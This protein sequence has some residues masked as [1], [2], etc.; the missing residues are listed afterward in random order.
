MLRALVLPAV[1]GLVM[2]IK[3]VQRRRDEARQVN[4]INIEAKTVRKLA[5]PFR[6]G[7]GSDDHEHRSHGR[8][9]EV[10]RQRMATQPFEDAERRQLR[11]RHRFQRNMECLLQSA[12]A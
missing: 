8:G 2:A 11:M 6:E 9:P 12:M 7:T 3:L 10:L 4:S 1:H 5:R